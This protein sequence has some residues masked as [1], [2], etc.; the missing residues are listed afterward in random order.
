[1]GSKLAEVGASIG[2]E[3]N[4]IK[5]LRRQR[6]RDILTRIAQASAPIL[7]VI[8]G[9]LA[10]ET[11][12]PPQYSSDSYP[13]ATVMLASSTR[14]HFERRP[15]TG[16]ILLSIGLF[17]VAFSFVALFNSAAGDNFGISTRYGVYP[18]RGDEHG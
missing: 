12:Y 7:S 18:G 3:D 11:K 10:A 2:M 8:L 15:W 17:I 4:D 6:R 1:M 13:Y 14:P 16:P 5:E 9:I